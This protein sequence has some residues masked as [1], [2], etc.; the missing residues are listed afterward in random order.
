MVELGVLNS[1]VLNRLKTSVRNCKRM[2][3]FT[4]NSLFSENA[5]LFWEGPNNWPPSSFPNVPGVCDTKQDES[6]QCV[7][8]G[9]D[10]LP[11]Q[12][13]SGLPE[14]PVPAKPLA[15]WPGVNDNPVCHDPPRFIAHPFMIWPSIPVSDLP[16]G[17]W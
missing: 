8:V 13:W 7:S 9:F 3:S 10:T 17:S 1:G 4:G 11:E 6:N 14:A 16:N 15:F 12:T 2:F 5:M